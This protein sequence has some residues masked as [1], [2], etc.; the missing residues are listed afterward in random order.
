MQIIES[1]PVTRFWPNR[2]VSTGSCTTL[3]SMGHIGGERWTNHT[4][5][6]GDGASRFF[7]SSGSH[8][9]SWLESDGRAASS[10]PDFGR[11]HRGMRST[12]SSKRCWQALLRDRERSSHSGEG[13]AQPAPA[14]VEARVVDDPVPCAPGTIVI[15]LRNSV[16]VHLAAG[17]DPA[18][19]R[20]VVDAL[21]ASA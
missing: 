19:L 11:N 3:R 14:F 10:L 7:H 9:L 15:E 21:G 6:H 8:E 13:R 5:R 17:F 16:R 18:L 2:V 1:S 12:K 4:S 20:Q